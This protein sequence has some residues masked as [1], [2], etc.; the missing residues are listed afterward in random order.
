MPTYEQ[1]LRELQ[2]RHGI[3]SPEPKKRYVV[4]TTRYGPPDPPDYTLVDTA[5]HPIQRV[6]VANVG[7][8]PNEILNELNR[9]ADLLEHKDKRIRELEE[10]APD[11]MTFGI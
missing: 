8:I 6:V 9:L 3:A 4:E 1:E 10:I 2:R 11:T 5:H 7:R